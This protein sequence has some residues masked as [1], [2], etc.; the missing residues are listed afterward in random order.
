MKEV[1]FALIFLLLFLASPICDVQ[2]LAGF[3]FCEA[4]I[5]YSLFC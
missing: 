4:V 1:A 3:F 5:L 2:W